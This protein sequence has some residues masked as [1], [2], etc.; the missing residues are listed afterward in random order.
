MEGSPRMVVKKP[1]SAMPSSGGQR[2]HSDQVS[3]GKKTIRNYT[4]KESSNLLKELEE[5]RR[6]NLDRTKPV[7]R[8]IDDFHR[9]LPTPP[10]DPRE[11]DKSARTSVAN[12]SSAAAT[13]Q[14]KKSPASAGGA[15]KNNGTMTSQISN[16][17]V[18]SS[19]AA[20]FDYQP[21]IR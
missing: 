12:A 18:A 6:K 11:L 8:M 14:G 3:M 9:N 21:G 2:Y 10:P 17:S 19:S 20:S 16:W 7:D 13:D 5:N 1:E 15:A 4:P